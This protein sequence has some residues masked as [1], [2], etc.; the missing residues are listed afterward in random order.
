MQILKCK[1][2]GWLVGI[3]AITCVSLGLGLA[4]CS[5]TNSGAGAV[6]AAAKQNAATK[7]QGGAQLWAQN[8]GHCHNIR[9]PDSYSD[10][11]W[12]VAMLHMRIRANLTP[13]EHN[14]ILVF[15]K[16]AH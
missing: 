11:Q 4:G 10:A 5:T 13:D 3:L 2:H 6:G 16:S 15:L 12:D 14:Q 1:N 8:C 9:S 7:G